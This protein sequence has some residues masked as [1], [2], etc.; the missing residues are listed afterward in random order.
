MDT[1]ELNDSVTE[2]SSENF[3]FGSKKRRPKKSQTTTT[4]TNEEV[5]TEITKQ[6]PEKKPEETSTATTSSATPQFTYEELVKR[7]YGMMNQPEGEKEKVKLKP[8]IVYRE[9]TTRTAWANFPLIC[10]ALHRQPDHLMSFFLAEVNSTGAV[11]GNG[12]L[13]FRG[14]LEQKHVEKI[15]K[16]Y[17][18]EYVTCHTCKSLETQLEKENRLTFMKCSKCG[19]KRS[20]A[21]IKSGFR[22]TDR[23]S[24]RAVRQE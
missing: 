13:V 21:P 3:D 14:R 24:R 7:L 2:N 19:S 8:P 10:S 22:A 5:Q 1:N 18:K 4:K 15:V 23:A 20:V 16:G 9:G 12:R 11:D 17:V 6:E